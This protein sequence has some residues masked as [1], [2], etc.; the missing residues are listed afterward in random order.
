MN[1]ALEAVS[2]Q[3]NDL[4][5]RVKKLEAQMKE[6]KNAVIKPDEIKKPPEGGLV[7]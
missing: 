5:E 2:A 4:Y 3:I 1:T 7:D 6:L